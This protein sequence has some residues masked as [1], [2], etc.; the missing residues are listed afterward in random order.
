MWPDESLDSSDGS[1]RGPAQSVEPTPRPSC[2]R[3]PTHGVFTGERAGR[4]LRTR[5]TSSLCVAPVNGAWMTRKSDRASS[6]T[7]DTASTSRTTCLPV[8]LPPSSSSPNGGR[9]FGDSPSAG[10]DYVSVTGPMPQHLLPEPVQ[11]R[12]HS[13]GRSL[14]VLPEAPAPPRGDAGVEAPARAGR[15]SAPCPRVSLFDHP[16]RITIYVTRESAPLG[17]R[18]RLGVALGRP[19]PSNPERGVSASPATEPGET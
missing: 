1:G 6:W 19:G 2:D 16:A 8:A 14:T 9:R 5:T 17:P 4:P 3:G 10:A 7:N 15:L 18:H 13:P 11:P 12:S